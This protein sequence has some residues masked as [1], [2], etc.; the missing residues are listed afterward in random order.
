MC[1]VGFDAVNRANVDS[2]T[3]HT[4]VL[5]DDF[6]DITEVASIEFYAAPRN[7][8]AQL[9]VGIYEKAGDALG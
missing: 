2:A 8:P 3:R 1:Y 6:T 7:Q 4:I 9:S 5:N